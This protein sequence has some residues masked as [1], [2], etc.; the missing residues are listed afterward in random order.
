[1]IKRGRVRIAKRASQ[2]DDS[3]LLV[4]FGVGQ[5]MGE[6]KIVAPAPAIATVTVLEPLELVCIDLDRMRK[7]H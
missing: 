1:M 2:G 7:R 4:E 3:H 6:E 5:T